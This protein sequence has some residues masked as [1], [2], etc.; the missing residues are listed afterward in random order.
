MRRLAPALAFGC[1]I[2]A[3]VILIGP[4]DL[5]SYDTAFF[6]LDRG[7]AVQSEH[8]LGHP[9]YTLSLGLGLRLPL[10]GSLGASPAAAL[11]PYV[12]MPITYG[13]LLV[14][15]IASAVMVVQFALEPICGRVI[16]WLAIAHLFCSLPLVTYTIAADWPE[17]AG[18]YIAIVACVFA[19]HALLAARGLP[20]SAARVLWLSVAGVV[21]S[22]ISVAHSGYWPHL[23]A[24]LVCAA[25]LALCRWDHPLRVRVAAVA[26]LAFVAIAAVGLQAPDILRELSLAGSDGVR[27]FVQGPVGN[28]F[29]ANL[30]P[31]VQAGA[32]MPFTSLLL[33]LVALVTGWQCDSP[34]DRWLIVASAMVS[35]LL[36]VGASTLRPGSAVFAPSNTWA[37]RD[38]AGAFALFSG[39]CAAGAVVRSTP[40]G[41]TRRTR[42]LLVVLALASLQGPFY[43]WR[44]VAHEMGSGGDPGWT[45]ELSSAE[46]RMA[47][48]GVSPDRLQPGTRLALWPGTQE[49]MRADRANTADFPDAGYELVTSVVKD[50]TMRRLITPNDLLFNQSTGLPADILC[51]PRAVQFLQLRYLVAPHD[52]ACP[53]RAASADEPWQP[54]PGVVVDRWLEV[55]EALSRDTQARAVSVADLT[56][57][58]SR[59][60]ALSVGSSLLDVLAP[61]PGT[62]VRIGPRGVVVVQDS[63]ARLKDRGIVLP[64]AYDSAWTTSSGQVRNIGGLLAVLN[65]DQPRTT[66]TF[67]PDA[68]AIL[69]ALGMTVAQLLA[70]GG[71]VGLA[72]VRTARLRDDALIAHER[73]IADSIHG[74]WRRAA[75]I[76]IPAGRRA[77]AGARP[78]LREP[79]NLLC[80]LYIAAVIATPHRADQ[81]DLS[82]ALLLPLA[83]IATARVS[84]WPA[85]R[86]GIAVMVLAAALVLVA[87]GG[88]RSAAALHDPLFW[89]IVTVAVA[90]VALFANRWPVIAVAASALAGATVAVATLLPSVQNFDVALP[91][92]DLALITQ[93]LTTMADQL[94]VATT[95]CVLALWVH[96]I[97]FTWRRARI[98]RVATGARSALLAALVLCLLGAIQMAP[99]TG[100]RIVALGCLLGLSI[101]SD[102]DAAHTRETSAAITL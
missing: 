99:L 16:A 97:A 17:I 91:R 60:P 37:I 2:A 94:G 67:V 52:A 30:F 41:R 79:Q 18:A 89:G 81:I 93:S 55:R 13:L 72:S 32:R 27:R 68:A 102:R 75:V 3:L 15:A 53:P 42:T 71:L 43:A 35:V 87:L 4:S 54:L 50:R 40:S 100:W 96:A 85:V 9:V 86:N 5:E 6:S 98:E 10:H 33:A 38:Y 78:V 46:M 64:V 19:P 80:L 56:E 70:I 62:A 22:L 84:R 90:V 82:T 36:G 29:S 7:T 51:D 14:V 28:V 25:A 45:R 65:V 34:R 20:G 88:S 44:V 12:P 11:S 58:L 83:T 47:R 92:I 63:A 61:V 66:L 1:V 8:V 48:R 74:W 59:E 73:R 23:A 26:T 31:F 21:W 77:I 95:M 39:A 24:T 76:V 57:R 49:R 101:R 69:L